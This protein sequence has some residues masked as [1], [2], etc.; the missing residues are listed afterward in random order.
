MA[1]RTGSGTYHAWQ[2]FLQCPDC[3]SGDVGVE[4]YDDGTMFN[5]RR[6][7][8]EAWASTVVRKE[9]P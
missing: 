7:G 2:D 8:A 5:C 6:C 3:G 9:E 4:H 1:R